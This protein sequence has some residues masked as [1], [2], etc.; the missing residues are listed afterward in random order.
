MPK[1]TRANALSGYPAWQRFSNEVPFNGA[2]PATNSLLAGAMEIP[3]VTRASIAGLVRSGKLKGFAATTVSSVPMLLDVPTMPE[4]G[5]PD[6]VMGP[7][8]GM[9]GAAA[10]AFFSESPEEYAE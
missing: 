8:D 5:Y 4:L 1:S 7:L 2:G 6:I 9:F 3:P 10:E